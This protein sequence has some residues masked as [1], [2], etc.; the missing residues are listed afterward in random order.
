VYAAPDAVTVICPL[1]PQAIDRVFPLLFEKVGH[2][3]VRLLRDNFPA[4]RVAT[5]FV[6]NASASDTPPV[7]DVL[8]TTG[9][10]TVTALDVIVCTV[11]VAPLNVIAFAPSGMVIALES[12][13]LPDIPKIAVVSRVPLNPVKS[14]LF[15]F[16][17]AVM[18]IESDPAETLKLAEI[19]PGKVIVKVRVVPTEGF[20]VATK[21]DDVPGLK[22]ALF[23]LKTVPLVAVK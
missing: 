16:V 19:A 9:L 22:V 12:V 18:T 23:E 21:L 3:N 20:A 13:R 1:V 15:T 5:R 17:A 14:K 2:V 4:V 7:P 11:A 8:N 6:V 10:F